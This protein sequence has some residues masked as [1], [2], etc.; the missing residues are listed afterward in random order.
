MSFAGH[1]FE[2]CIKMHFCCYSIIW[3][4]AAGEKYSFAKKKEKVGG[5]KATAGICGK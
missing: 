3:I 1:K 4:E 5:G 2:C